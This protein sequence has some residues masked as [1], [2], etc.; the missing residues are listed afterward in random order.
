[1]T[2]TQF[3]NKWIGKSVDIDKVFGKQCVDLVKQYMLET[4]KIPNG[5]Y[6]NA[7]DY[8]TRTHT[9]I[10]KHYDRVATN[11]PR[12]GDI[13][14]LKGSSGNP[15]GHIGIASG[16]NTLVTAQILE[17]NGSAGS[18]T[19]LGGDAIR[20]RHIPKWRIVGVLRPKATPK[21]PAPKPPAQVHYI[22]K[23]GDTMSGIAKK[24]GL[25][26]AR[27]SALNPA[28]K[29]LNKISVGQKVRVK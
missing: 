12:Q 21:P 27:L 28:I 3:K 5:A 4:K 1:M 10:R 18:G 17:Q 8:W 16:S 2:Y 25:T 15:Y 22:V 20:L 23:R 19:G 24:H 6:G 29:N 14:I 7:I 9:T 13:V 11:N 26:L